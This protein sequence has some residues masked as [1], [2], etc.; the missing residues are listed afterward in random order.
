MKN[1]KTFLL[2]VDVQFF[3]Y[4]LRSSKLP[5]KIV[6]T[7]DS[8]LKNKYVLFFLT[9]ILC[10]AVIW[11]WSLILEVKISPQL[12]HRIL[13]TFLFMLCFRS[14]WYL[15]KPF[16]NVKKRIDAFIQFQNMKIGLIFYIIKKNFKLC[17]CCA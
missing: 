4:P 15:D 13:S 10:L 17:L 12:G 6:Y 9:L 16:I 3:I 14:M 5:P 2:N 8:W 7:P 1:Q 11:I